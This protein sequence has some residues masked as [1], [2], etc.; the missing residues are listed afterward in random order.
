M[1]GVRHDRRRD[2]EGIT[3][4]GLIIYALLAALFLGVVASLFLTGLKSEA[5]TRERD[6]ATGRAQV[7][8]DSLQTSVRNASAFQIDGSLLRAR[9]ATGASGWQCRAWV[10]SGGKLLYTASTTAIVAGTYTGWTQLAPGAAGT[11]TG[12]VPF[13][14]T[15]T[16]T[17]NIGLTVTVGAAT[18]P[19]TSGVTAQARSEGTATPCW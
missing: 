1:T 2:D 15:G 19:V 12:G 18:V 9:V 17:L 4:V 3:L 5:A 6:T 14:K 8:T 10:V 16:S 13:T 11:L 7:V